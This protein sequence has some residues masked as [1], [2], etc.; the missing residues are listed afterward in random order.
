MRTA[1]SL[2]VDC[3]RGC[4][5]PVAAGK[6]SEEMLKKLYPAQETILHLFEYCCPRQT[7]AKT[8]EADPQTNKEWFQEKR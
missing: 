2:R 3:S 4:L 7:L 1:L 6:F 5:I 8:L